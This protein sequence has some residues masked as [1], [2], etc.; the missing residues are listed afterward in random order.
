MIDGLSKKLESTMA[1]SLQPEV[2]H[3]EVRA[4]RNA[5]SPG[6]I[7]DP[8]GARPQN[9]SP[10][11]ATELQTVMKALKRHGSKAKSRGLRHHAGSVAREDSLMF[12]RGDPTPTS[13]ISAR[14]MASPG[15][16]WKRGWPW[17][18]ANE[19]VTAPDCRMVDRCQDYVTQ[20]KLSNLLLAFDTAAL[21]EKYNQN[22]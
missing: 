20:I 16:G 15:R 5:F 7:P 18:G 11:Y 6:A 1:A 21:Q 2:A 9:N 13:R 17:L 22:S 12:E 14:C 10:A 4:W 3:Y 19:N 8:H